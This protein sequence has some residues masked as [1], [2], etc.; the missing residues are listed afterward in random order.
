M[1]ML[2]NIQIAGNS[3]SFTYYLFQQWK[4]GI[5]GNDLGHSNNGENWTI[6]SQ[7]SHVDEGSTTRRMLVGN[8]YFPLKV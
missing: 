4:S 7:A 6:R 2:Q 8:V 3:L 5:Q 1:L